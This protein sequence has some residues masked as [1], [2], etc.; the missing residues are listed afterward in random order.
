MHHCRVVAVFHPHRV[1]VS[2][3]TISIRNHKT[4]GTFY[5]SLTPDIKHA[6][7]FEMRCRWTQGCSRVM[8]S[9]V[10]QTRKK[11]TF[12][13]VHTTRE[14]CHVACERP[15]R[16]ELAIR[17]RGGCCPLYP[18]KP[19]S[20]VAHTLPSH[21]AKKIS[22]NFT[23]VA[24]QQVHTRFSQEM[25]TTADDPTVYKLSTLIYVPRCR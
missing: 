15:P 13:N 14:F 5:L 22:L 8:L 3:P 23:L 10:L 9:S 19:Q 18:R 1:P 11:C 2:S 7:S 16:F 24:S 25:D 12:R 17:R 20:R 6:V 21:S 4:A